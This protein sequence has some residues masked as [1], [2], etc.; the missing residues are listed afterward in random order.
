MAEFNGKTGVWR[1]IGGRKV[2]IADG[3]ELSDAMK[4]SGKFKKTP[5]IDEEEITMGDYSLGA[6][7]MK[8]ESGTPIA[9]LKYMKLNDMKKS[10]LYQSM[11][12]GK[13]IAIQMIE[14]NEEYRRR[15]YATALFKKLQ[16]KYPNEEM[17][18]GQLEP[19]GEKLL[20]SIAKITSSELL[21][22][23][24]RKTYYGKIK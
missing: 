18:F 23:H 22:G 6:L 24:K 12:G 8:D 17:R 21:E 11:F 7:Y 16:S 13:R 2:F 10:A 19:D 9:Y 4:K 20:K 5:K 15:G 3:Q 14:V 1:T